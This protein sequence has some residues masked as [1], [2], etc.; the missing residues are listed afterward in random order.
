MA[1]EVQL[2]VLADRWQ[3]ELAACPRTTANRMDLVLGLLLHA[4]GGAVVTYYGTVFGLT[5]GRGLLG[6]G[7]GDVLAAVCGL[8]P[9]AYVGW[10]ALVDVARRSVHYR[11]E[12]TPAG[13]RVRTWREGTFAWLPVPLR[14][15]GAVAM[16]EPWPAAVEGS[17]TDFRVEWS[18]LRGTDLQPHLLALEL[19]A[20]RQIGLAIR[21]QTMQALQPITGLVDAGHRPGERN[22]VPADLEALL[23]EG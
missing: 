18:A 12:G 17:L 6:P 15:L 19:S 2:E 9:A 11:V 1:D 10:H 7:P 22:E 20:D 4:F 21:G 8:L 14:W 3:M 16:P 5:I 13:L 23:P